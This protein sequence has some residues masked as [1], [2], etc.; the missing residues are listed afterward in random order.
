MTDPGDELGKH[1]EMMLL[2]IPGQSES[3]S[4]V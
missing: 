4:Q 3:I 2:P 1:K